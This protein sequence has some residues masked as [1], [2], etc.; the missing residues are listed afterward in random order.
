VSISLDHVT[1][2]FGV[3]FGVQDVHQEIPSGALTAI[4]GPSGAGKSTLLRLIGGLVTPDEGRIRIDGADVTDV[5]PRH[6]NIGFCFQS[7]APFRHMTVARNV[8]YGLR[9]R[10]RPKAE[11]RAKVDEMLELVRLAPLARRYPAQLSGGEQQRLALARALAIEPSVLL[12]DEPFGALDAQV[13]AELRAWIRELHDQVHVTTVLVTHDQHEALELADWLLVLNQG[14]V[15]QAGTP[16][17]LYDRPATEFVLRFLGPSTTFDGHAV[18]PH[19]LELVPTGAGTPGE[20]RELVSLG[21][22]I[23]VALRLDDGQDPWVQVSR[24]ELDALSVRPGDRVGVRR[25]RTGTAP[26]AGTPPATSRAGVGAGV[27]P[28]PLPAR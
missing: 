18:R 11:I 23:R 13:R 3:A 12:L 21:F 9:V 6:R 26:T 7:Y 22:E 19:D 5:D 27:I 20:V 2:R 15:E 14:A 24:A 25:R 16:A 17:E 10:H 8:G 4:L 28:S 1:K